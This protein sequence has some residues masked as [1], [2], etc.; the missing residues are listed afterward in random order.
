MSDHLPDIPDK[1]PEAAEETVFWIPSHL[2]RSLVAGAVSI[3]AGGYAVYE[4]RQVTLAEVLA[5]FRGE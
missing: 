1:I 4:F 2:T 3:L 5:L